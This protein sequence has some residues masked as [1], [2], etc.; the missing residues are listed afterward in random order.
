[1]HPAVCQSA[2]LADASA[3]SLLL[4]LVHGSVSV[5]VEAR[6]DSDQLLLFSACLHIDGMR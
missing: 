1:M 2:R 4:S 6:Q 5:S 3:W